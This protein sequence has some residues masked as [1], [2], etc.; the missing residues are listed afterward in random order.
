MDNFIFGKL[1]SEAIPHVW[2][3][4]GATLFILLIGILSVWAIIKTKCWDWL[5][6]EWL[7]STDP[8]KIGTMYILFAA[9]MFFRGFLDAGMIWI[10]QLIAKDSQGYLSPDHFQQI[11]TSHGDIMVF[12]VTM[13]FFF[14]LMNWMIPLQIG[15]RDLAYPFLN[16]LGLWLTVFGGILI[17]LFFV[18]GGDFSNTGW[19]AFAPLSETE[20]NPGVGVDYLIWSLQ[21]SG[22]GSL[23]AAI[24]LIATIIKER[25]P[26]M[27]LMK[28]PLFIWAS[29][30]GMILIISA[31]PVLTATLYLLWLD[32]FFDMHFFTTDLGGN[33]MMY[34]NLIWMWGHPEVY[35]LVL[36]AFGMYS[37]IVAT[38]ARKTICGYTSMVWALIAITALSYLV[39]LHHFFTMGAGP[40]V[41]SFFGIV[42]ML[43]AIPSG[44][45]VFNWILT[46]YKGKL[47]FASPMY[48]FMG[49]VL[50]FC[51]GGMAG[52]LMAS[53][54]SRL[55]NPQFSISSCPLPHHGCRHCYLWIFCRCDFLVSENFWF[56]AQRKTW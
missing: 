25:A 13:G 15:A 54:P 28:M 7:T 4:I 11:F 32:R 5:W 9:I 37:E 22:L 52:V 30:C 48:W 20:F 21:L 40:D 33:Q 50:L 44:V 31:F 10:Q 2:Y 14:G 49:F 29:L 42:T 51:F 19:L 34:F 35:I 56:Y 46:M 23:L 1:T 47:H 38:F 43:I 45:Q 36:P 27:T 26:G 6:H 17:N 53:P 39:W 16:S 24:N 41:N 55:P 12:F 3:T 8:K 18:V